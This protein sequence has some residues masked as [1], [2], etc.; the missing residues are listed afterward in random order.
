MNEHSMTT[1]KVLASLAIGFAANFSMTLI[2]A[3]GNGGIAIAV[4]VLLTGLGL[5]FA[6]FVLDVIFLPIAVVNLVIRVASGKRIISNSPRNNDR[7]G[8]FG[9]V[10]F[11]L[12]FG[13]VSAV[14][15]IF[16]G[17]MDGGM[18]WF[19]TSALFGVV[20]IL[21]AMLMPEDLMWEAEHGETVFSEPT[22]DSDEDLRQAREEGNPSVL[23]ADKF[24]RNV[25]DVI[26]EKPGTDDKP[27]A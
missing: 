21:L 19:S 11:V 10:L 1:L 14:T 18:G 7:V 4:G 15:G 27:R 3:P 26:I 25:I 23:F 20:G 22:S 6:K 13:F 16:I 8:F 24:A 5:V 9:R 17:A 12:A 2:A